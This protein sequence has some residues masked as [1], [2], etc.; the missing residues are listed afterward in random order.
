MQEEENFVYL[1]WI[2]QPYVGS[3]DADQEDFW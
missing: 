2:L 3:L 1:N